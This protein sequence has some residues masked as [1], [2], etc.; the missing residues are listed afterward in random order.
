MKAKAF[1]P[2]DREA[3]L[4]LANLIA[5][6]HLHGRHAAL[7]GCALAE[8]LARLLI[9]YDRATADRLLDFHIATVLE[10]M[11]E[12]RAMLPEDWRTERYGHIP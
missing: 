8:L 10:L 6:T 12:T 2:P 1:P 9:N 11:E 3:V 4:E 7:V 5:T